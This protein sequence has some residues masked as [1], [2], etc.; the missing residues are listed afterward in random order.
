MPQFSH[1]GPVAPIAHAGFHP[2][3]PLPGARGALWGSARGV[4]SPPLP[5]QS[6]GG[7]GLQ[8]GPP[9]SG[10]S[11]RAPQ[12]IPVHR[13]VKSCFRFFWMAGVVPSGT[14]G[15]AGTDTA[16][17]RVEMGVWD[18]V[19]AFRRVAFCRGTPLPDEPWRRRPHS[20][21][22]LSRLA[23]NPLRIHRPNGVEPPTGLC[24]PGRVFQMFL[25]SFSSIQ[26]TRRHP[27]CQ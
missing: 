27:G 12:I 13:R 26:E 16:I 1:L 3:C 20:R 25:P 22:V 5:A 15:A 7:I 4:R 17:P 2:A 9:S 24:D 6:F 19:L 18:P 21:F 11:E 8:V 10:V 14:C 23:W